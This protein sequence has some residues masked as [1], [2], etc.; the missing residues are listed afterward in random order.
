M[1]QKYEMRTGVREIGI[2]VELFRDFD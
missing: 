1:V 2:G